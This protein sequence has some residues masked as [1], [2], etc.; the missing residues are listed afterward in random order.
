MATV[1]LIIFTYIT[2][3]FVHN[4]IRGESSFIVILTYYK[5]RLGEEIVLSDVS[6]QF[7]N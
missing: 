5:V 3:Y 4:A 7:E 6:V 2:F 1:K